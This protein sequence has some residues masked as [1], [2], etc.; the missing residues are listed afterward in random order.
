MRRTF[1]P[2]SLTSVLVL[3][4]FLFS[5]NALLFGGHA[6]EEVRELTPWAAT[7]PADEECQHAHPGGDLGETH[8]ESHCCDAQHSHDLNDA[9]LFAIQSPL[10]FTAPY[11]AAPTTYPAE[12]FYD[13]F[14]PPQNR[15]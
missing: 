9:P 6:A 7:M 4:T 15:I 3:L 13:R 2:K 10:S 8:D 5:T 1:F 14:I 12:V 11:G